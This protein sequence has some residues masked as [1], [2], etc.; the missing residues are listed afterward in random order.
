LIKEEFPHISFLIELRF[1]PKDW[2]YYL[3]VDRDWHRLKEH[4]SVHTGWQYTE[5]VTAVSASHI[6]R[7]A[8]LI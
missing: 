5:A 6:Y 4:T 1:A 7:K 3:K 8:K 2:F